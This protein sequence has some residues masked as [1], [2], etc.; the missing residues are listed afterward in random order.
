VLTEVV[1]GPATV[2]TTTT[3]I[4]SPN[5]AAVGQA[6][7]LTATVVEVGSSGVPTGTVTFYDGTAS[8]GA[9]TLSSGIATYS[10]S[11]LAVGTHSL[12]AAYGGDLSNAASTSSAVTITITAIATD[13]SIALSPTSGTASQGSTATS[14][15]TITPA[16]GFNQSVSFACS[17]L[18][19]K[20]SCSFSPISVTPS[21]TSGVT[22]TLT[23]N[24]DVKTSVLHQ[25][26]LHGQ[27]SGG[28]VAL[29][30]LA[31]GSWL[32]FLL[33]GSRSRNRNWW[34]LHLGMISVLLVASAVMGCGGS[35]TTTPKGTSQITVTATSGSTT[36]TAT[37]SL[38]IQ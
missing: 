12:T 25:P 26:P 27:K 18:P 34:C 20:T 17:G 28:V 9:G 15:I 13:F 4:G 14:T 21:G 5:F 10:A 19:A 22:S 2:G 23:I 37:Y 1:N 38:T 6:V 33:L 24:T 36:H 16:G 32:G 29:A 35:S 30:S 3:L 31:G 7:T 8:L 11:S